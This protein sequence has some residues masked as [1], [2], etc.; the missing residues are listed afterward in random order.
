MEQKFIKFFKKV[1]QIRKEAI[2]LDVSPKEKMDYLINKMTVLLTSNDYA[3]HDGRTRR[4][5]KVIPE[6]ESIEQYQLEVIHHLGQEIPLDKRIEGN[7]FHIFVLF[8]GCSSL[9]DLKNIYIYD[10]GTHT[11]LNRYE[12]LHD[13]WCKY[14]N[15]LEIIENRKNEL[16]WYVLKYDLKTTDYNNDIVFK[17]YEEAL[18]EFNQTKSSYKDEKIEIIF[19]PQED[20]PLY[21]DN[22]LI[23]EKYYKEGE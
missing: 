10:H 6:V 11:Y 4:D 23:L 9:N 2:D 14:L 3:M 16:D 18:K 5:L 17:T 13:K 8:D 12:E 22:E 21:Y 20:D 1:N 15:Q 7:I 19:S